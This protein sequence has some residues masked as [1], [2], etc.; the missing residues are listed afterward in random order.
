MEIL[1][2]I[3]SPEPLEPET[4]R[5]LFPELSSDDIEKILA[6]KVAFQTNAPFEDMDIFENL[7]Y[8]LN[9]VKPDVTKMEG[10]TP[11]MVWDAIFE[12]KKIRKEFEF[13]HEVLMYIKYIFTS[14]GYYFYPENIGLENKH[15]E[16]IKN[17]LKEKTPLEE[18]FIDIQATKYKEIIGN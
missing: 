12:I 2:L 13:A 7:V 1:D 16:L 17:R 6:T 3:T 11:K 10:C 5:E 14:N 18:N 15:M 8:V 4:I 9:G